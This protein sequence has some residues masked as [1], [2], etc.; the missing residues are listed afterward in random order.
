MP[1]DPIY[2]LHGLLGTAS[3]H[4]G[5]Q[6]RTWARQHRVIAVDLP[7]HG[8]CPLDAADAYLDQA[9]GYVTTVLTRFGPGRV[10]A[11][12]YLGGPIAIHV[13]A[14]RPDLVTSLVLTGFVPGLEQAAF[15]RMLGG[16]HVLA[17]EQ[18]GLAAE[19]ERLHGPRWKDTLSAYG[20][21]CARHP[22]RVLPGPAVLAGLDTRTHLVNGSH[23]TAERDA[24]R[25][26]GGIGPRVSGVVIDGAGHIAGHDAPEAFTA[27]VEAFWAGGAR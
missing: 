18:P 6:M 24:A 7:G 4:F 27:A 26:A 16:F 12:S 21:D 15:L 10:V 8:R 5:A 13:A 23:K 17:A 20:E 3:A 25:T 1:P 14:T 11:A 9:V 2:L 22:Q 19:Y